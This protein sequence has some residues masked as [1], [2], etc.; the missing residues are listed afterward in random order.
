MAEPTQTDDDVLAESRSRVARHVL[1]GAL[2]VGLIAE[3]LLYSALPG[4]NFLLVTALFCGALFLV[5]RR[6][7]LPLRGGGRF[8][9]LPALALAACLVVRDTPA[10]RILTILALLLCLAV[11]CFRARH[12]RVLIGSLFDYVTAALD[13]ALHAAG[14][15]LFALGNVRWRRG[16]SSIVA[17]RVL[18]GALIATPLLLI[19]GG[20][21]ALADANFAALLDSLFSSGRLFEHALL[22]IVLAWFSAGLL[23]LALGSEHALALEQQIPKRNAAF[24]IGAIEIGVV[25]GSLIALFA[26]FVIT[27]LRYF[28][29]GAALVLDTADASNTL[30]F[31]E[32]ARRGFFEL[33]LVAALVLAVLL[34]GHFITR[35]D[36]PQ[37]MR[38]FRALALILTGLVFVIIASALHRMWTYMQA[39]GL[40]ELRVYTSAFMV[41]L[42]FVFAWFVITTLR[43]SAERFAFG[44]VLS[45]LGVLFALNLANPVGFIVR[46]NI[47]RITNASNSNLP[48][49][50]AERID[51]Q[52]LSQ[53]ASNNADALPPLMSNLS[54]F[55]PEDRCM[56]AYGIST[57]YNNRSFAPETPLVRESNVSSAPVLVKQTTDWRTW[58]I[59]R[60]QAHAWIT[61][62]LQ[63][64][65][66][67]LACFGER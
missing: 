37:P 65:Y 57:Y 52:Y 47:E 25:L 17:V 31:A 50:A 43:G 60:A 46:H 48:E 44:F 32:Y 3:Q 11:L 16:D 27:Q 34:G 56:I 24:G 59:A 58:N 51:A 54:R 2:G 49:F 23:W 29:G 61:P 7:G 33:V 36:T 63:Q 64:S 9:A 12:T 1:G 18:I 42:A 22:L 13:S 40:T 5:A 14:G 21:F 62:D 30:T 67:D 4:V 38:L 39:Y 10:L 6:A 35:R 45:A 28:F 19:F 20:L 66:M 53:L 26:A 8:F 15:G 41:W 55:A